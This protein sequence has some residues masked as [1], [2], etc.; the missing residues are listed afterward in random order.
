MNLTPM[1]IIIGA[2]RSGTT[3]LRLM[4]DSHPDL[5]IPPETGFLLGALELTKRNN[6]SAQQL[7]DMTTQ[8]PDNAPNWADFQIPVED[9]LTS[10]KNIRPFDIAEGLR[11]FYRL[12]AQRFGK[13]RWGD[14]TPDYSLHVQ[15]IGQMLPEAHF[16]HIIR[17]GRDAALSLR[18]TWF[19]PSQ[20]M[21]ILAQYWHDRVLSARN[22]SRQTAHYLEIFYEDLILRPQV[23]LQKI[24]CFLSLNFHPD[25]LNYHE[26]APARLKEHQARIWKDGSFEVSH[27]QRLQQQHMTTQKLSPDRVAVWK[28]AMTTGE[29]Q[30]FEQVAGSMLS[31]LGYP[32]KSR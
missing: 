9:L 25:M 20:D 8:Y 3:L 15:A 16:I 24:C 23:N 18:S 31:E 22:A 17:D 29:V 21:G 19:A 28:H 1:P 13:S 26:R 12:Y 4:L 30:Q 32:L 14:K 27:E 5:A 6:V 2:P 7:V 11:C 10:V